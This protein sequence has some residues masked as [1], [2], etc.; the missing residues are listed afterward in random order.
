M[1]FESIGLWG[2]F[3]QTN[4]VRQYFQ[5]Q[6]GTK[7][8]STSCWGFKPTPQKTDW[9]GQLGMEPTRQYKTINLWGWPSDD[10]VVWSSTADA[11]RVWV[12]EG[13]S[14]SA[15]DRH[16]PG[17]GWD[18]LCVYHWQLCFAQ[19]PLAIHWWQMSTTVG[20]VEPAPSMFFHM[21]IA[22]SCFKGWYDYRNY[23]G[24]LNLTHAQWPHHWL[25]GE[26]T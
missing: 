3:R 7:W 13:K 4:L 11:C 16:D 2:I 21:S 18:T 24:N 22:W 20:E 5:S 26:Q 17:L 1:R 8:R 19:R 25:G 15:Q 23:T 9:A 12:G 6:D 10:P 14:A